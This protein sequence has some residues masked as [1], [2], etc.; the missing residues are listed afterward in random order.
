MLQPK[1]GQLATITLEVQ[2]VGHTSVCLRVPGH[3]NSIWVNSVDVDEF[4]DKPWEPKVGET[5]LE[6]GDILPNF[7][8]IILSLHGSNT[9][10]AYGERRRWASIAHGDDMP[11]TVNVSR[12]VRCVV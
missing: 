2:T 1:V 8:Y 12:L 11:K 3:I 4:R 9:M 10:M 7:E 5:V 6:N